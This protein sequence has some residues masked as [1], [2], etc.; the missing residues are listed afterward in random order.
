MV[1]QDIILI[2]LRIRYLYVLVKNLN[3][4]LKQYE[5][6]KSWERKIL[7]KIFNAKN[8]SQGEYIRSNK[9]IDKLIEIK[10]TQRL[11]WLG[12]VM[13]QRNGRR[14][15]H[16]YIEQDGKLKLQWR[17]NVQ[18]DFHEMRERNWKKRCKIEPSA[19]TLWRKLKLIIGCSVKR[20]SKINC[21][22]EDLAY[23]YFW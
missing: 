9:K 11:K 12:H 4:L 23:T 21:N 18:E 2:L 20:R 7:R 5:M 8:T 14:T 13:R 3:I 17:D 1:I 19:R 22:V 15:E 16:T 6:K 10:A